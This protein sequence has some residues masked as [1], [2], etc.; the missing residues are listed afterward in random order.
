MKQTVQKWNE[1]FTG[2][3]E[4]Q[5][6]PVPV[7]VGLVVA[8]NIRLIDAELKPVREAFQKLKDESLEV[9]DGVQRIKEESNIEA[10]NAAA[11][12]LNEGELEIAVQLIQYKSLLE[13]RIKTPSSVFTAA[14]EI[15]EFEPEPKKKP[16]PTQKPKKGAI[17]PETE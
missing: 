7:F 5:K 3:I 16:S 6:A 9:V 15:F 8:K 13:E 11:K 10:F 1:I 12:S 14:M 17:A 2:L 4:L